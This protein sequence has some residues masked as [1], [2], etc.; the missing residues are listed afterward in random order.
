MK[1]GIIGGGASGVFAAIAAKTKHPEADVYVLEKGAKMLAK[2][3]ITGGG[4]C[5][6]TN[7]CESISDFAA[8]FPR[9]NKNM[10]KLFHEFNNQD[11]MKWFQSR[12]VPL[13]VQEDACVFPESQD[14]QS[15]IDCLLNECK[16]LGVKMLTKQHVLELKQENN[17]WHCLFKE[18]E[19]KSFD[20]VIVTT[21][22]SPTSRGLEWLGK[23]GH[24]IVA[25]VPS[26]FTMNMPN[27]KVRELMGVV[28]ENTLVSIQGTKFKASGPL[29]ITHWGMSGPSVLKLSAFG[30]RFLNEVQYNY[31]LQ[32]NWVNEINTDVVLHDI[33]RIC[34]ANAQKNMGNVRPYDLP[35]RLW[36]Y[37]LEKCGL[38]TQKKWAELGKK[39]RNKLVE[40][41]CND[42]YQV[43]GK[44]TFKEEFVTSGGVSLSDI[45][46]KTLQ[47]KKVEGLYFAGEVMNIDAITGG[48]N[49]QGAW[50]SGFVAGQLR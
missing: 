8:A 23:L 45:N 6:V 13:V 11:T 9:G 38:S 2:V 35:N 36:S 47:S 7:A 25:P 14:S 26:L 16:R 43:Q 12:G 28:V 29:L 17:L 44:S 18:Q 31:K 22:G 39:G 46:I 41:L 48:Y 42:V 30:A 1:V 21:G 15:I 33:E 5:N 10:R 20:K 50:T 3:K 37:L 49:L 34:T 40:A 19:S 24:E 4:R 27:E 32:V